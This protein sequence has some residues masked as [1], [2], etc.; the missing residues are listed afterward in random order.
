MIHGA[1][2]HRQMF[3]FVTAHYH[4]QHDFPLYNNA[5]AA[6]SSN[7]AAAS[8]SRRGGSSPRSRSPRWTSKDLAG[9]TSRP[10]SAGVRAAFGR[11]SSL[12]V[13]EEVEKSPRAASGQRSSSS[14][15]R[16]SGSRRLSMAEAD[17]VDAAVEEEDKDDNMEGGNEDDMDIVIEEV[18]NFPVPS[19]GNSSVG[20]A[21]VADGRSRRP[22]GGRFFLLM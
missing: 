19:R 12:V 21:S 7:A 2:P 4:Q 18:E 9:T 16:N 6:S 5:A 8:S 15:R 17:G 22:A 13:E 1:F 20:T 14:R 3:H 10:H 11:S